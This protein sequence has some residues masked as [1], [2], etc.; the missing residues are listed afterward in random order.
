MTY[1]FRTGKAWSAAISCLLLCSVF[2]FNISA[3][4]IISS[5]INYF[6]WKTDQSRMTVQRR[7]DGQGISLDE[8]SGDLAVVSSYDWISIPYY[9]ED[10]YMYQISFTTSATHPFR[11]NKPLQLWS[12]NISSQ[13]VVLWNNSVQF[14]VS[15]SFFSESSVYTYT[16]TGLDRSQLMAENGVA[17][18][19]PNANLSF[20]G[21]EFYVLNVYC[22]LTGEYDQEAYDNAVYSKL[23]DIQSSIDSVGDKVDNVGEKVDDLKDTIVTEHIVEEEYSSEKANNSTDSANAALDN[24]GILPKSPS[25]I[26]AGLSLLIRGISTDDVQD[27]IDIPEVSVPSL[28]VSGTSIGGFKLW[29]AQRVDLS[30]F[31]NSTAILTLRTWTKVFYYLFFIFWAIKWLRLLLQHITMRGS[32]IN[33]D[34][35]GSDGNNDPHASK[36]DRWG[37]KMR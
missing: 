7:A 24:L 19:V 21:G 13:S 3:S 9:Y 35:L 30:V 22:G 16:W 37:I 6:G 2:S 33:E 10:D 32:S 12:A 28:T 17:V 20:N 5:S 15:C 4:K 36:S 31:L 23:E 1:F 8:S 25:T 27:Y 34:S 18:V 14:D 26:S 11:N 29:D